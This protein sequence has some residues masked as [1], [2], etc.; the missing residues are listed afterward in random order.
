[1][2]RLWL[3]L[4]GGWSGVIVVAAIGLLG[5]VSTT[6][7]E[8]PS[9]G[10][11]VQPLQVSAGIRVGRT[12]GRTRIVVDLS[13]AV[14]YT[15]FNL[16]RPDRLVI[17]LQNTQLR[18]LPS[19]NLF[20]GTPV[21][22]MRSSIR[23]ESD[24]RLMVD[25]ECTGLRREDFVL[26]PDAHGGH[27]LV[28]DL[29]EEH[30]E[31]LAVEQVD[32]DSAAVTVSPPATRS[33]NDVQPGRESPAPV[34]ASTTEGRFEA[35]TSSDRDDIWVGGYG[36]L[37]AAYT[38]AGT[39]HW[40]QLRSRFEL[41]ASGSL[42]ENARFRIVGRAEVDGAY[43][44]EDDFYPSTV[45][46]NQSSDFTVREAYLDISSDDWEYRLGRQQ[47]VW[48]EMVGLFLADVV[49]A[50]DTREFNLPEFETMR[51]P[52]W[53]VRAERFAGDS[54]FELLWI[55]YTSYNEVGKPG[56]DF[57][58][59][60]IAADEP[61][62][63]V[64]PDR[65]K[66]SNTNFGAR[67]S[68][69]VAGWDLT[70]FYYQSN[71]VNPTLYTTESGL[72]LRH[73]RVQQIGSTFSK[74]YADF[75]LKGEAVYTS[76]RG[77]LTTD[78]TARFGLHDSDS[79]DYIVGVTIPKGDWRFDAQFYGR[80]VFDHDSSMLFD[81]DEFGITLLANRRF[82][83]QFEAELLY[84]AGLNRTDYSVQYNMTWN[85]TQTWH[86]KFGV[87]IFGGS[88]VGF[89]GRFDDSDRV[90]IALKTWF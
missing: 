9:G 51:I 15:I 14:Q 29:Y 62:N 63:E 84:L 38:V 68:R 33:T 83:D 43:A 86:L 88:E 79:L 78:P 55:P 2:D 45:R 40:S 1:M 13:Q 39:P 59:F 32:T 53:A 72:E 16:D 58:P 46:R 66:L 80:T 67:Y 37:G 69:L 34:I 19:A 18:A 7:Q 23:N 48:G 21:A 30:D 73:D 60:P 70:A 81:A 24:L 74:G 26:R 6:A 31:Q 44:L 20:V 12:P 3:R 8:S 54:H 28:L 61:V 90:F 11:A 25:L 87:D 47:V 82:G 64:I 35:R 77:F 52:Q 5:A 76:G 10:A 75:V 49:S 36:E 27:R 56:A 4:L 17:D 89:L 71:D 42:S 65:S 85:V 22:G 57:Y 50:R 41:G